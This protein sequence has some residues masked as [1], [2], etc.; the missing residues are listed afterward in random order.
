MPHQTSSLKGLVRTAVT[1]ATALLVV[2]PAIGSANDFC[3]DVYHGGKFGP[4]NFRPA[5][6]HIDKFNH[7]NGNKY[8]GVV[9]SSFFNS[10][11][12]PDGMGVVGFFERDLVARIQGIGYRYPAWFNVNRDVEVLTDLNSPDFLPGSPAG[13]GT[14]T[15]PNEVQRVPDG[16][17]AFEAVVSPQ[18]FH[19]GYAPGRLSLINLDHPDK[20]EYIIDQSLETAG[21]ACRTQ[22]NALFDPL[23]KPWFY[24]LVK[25][26]DMDGDGLKD[27]VTVR[28]GFRVRGT[29]C[30]P[31]EGE[32]VWFKNPGAAID[33][34]VEWEE[35][36]IAGYPSSQWSA[37]ISLDMYDLTGDGVPE[38]VANR[39]FGGTVPGEFIE[40]YGARVGE[41]WADVD[42]VSNPARTA[43]ISDNQGRPFGVKFV[44]LNRDGRMEVLA[45]NHQSDN[46]FRRTQ[47]AIPARVYALQQPASG[48]VFNDPWI[49]HILKDNIRPNP[50]YPAL[51]LNATTG[52]P[53]PAGPGRLAPGIAQEFWPTPWD[54]NFFRPWILVGGD[55]ASKV[56]LL[57]PNTQNQNDWSYGSAVIFD[58]ND[59]YGPNTSQSL[60]APA[61]DVGN[62][63]STLGS[64]AWRYD[65]D[66][67]WGS[68]AEIYIPVF[69]ARD[70]HRISFRPGNPATK[71]V[72]PPDGALACPAF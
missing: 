59:Y 36:V 69:E 4:L 42:P 9:F 39:F 70:I 16:I 19:P 18:G 20:L 62:S 1:A 24:H 55:E 45:T 8:D 57:K 17:L 11:K 21:I 14:Q 41:T 61:P 27:A 28:S 43:V 34:G 63:I 3:P 33:P 46:C 71:I 25:W 53:D 26:Y 37:D 67:A 49:T 6:L 66:W 64:P 32:V 44:D 58:I 30:I 31:P 40:I 60:T 29:F 38:I 35:F 13:P 12:N 56:W 65:R 15:W 7:P 48:D 54:E 5:F 2:V 72:C 22:D 51:P 23:T 50:T 47:D 52:D 68:Y 10:I